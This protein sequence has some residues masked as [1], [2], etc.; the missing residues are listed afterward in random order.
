ML[1]GVILSSEDMT[2]MFCIYY[3]QV[4]ESRVIC[5]SI[6]QT[7]ESGALIVVCLVAMSG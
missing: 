2:K 7:S 5:K 4:R 1:D 3:I 6:K